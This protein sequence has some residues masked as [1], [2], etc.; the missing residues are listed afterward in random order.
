MYPRP[1]SQH[2]HA[3]SST[4]THTGRPHVES[5]RRGRHQK[6]T[7]TTSTRP[8]PSSNKR[9]WTT[10]P[11]PSFL[12]LPCRLLP[13]Q[14]QQQQQQQEQQE[15]PLLLHILLLRQCL[16][17]TH[18]RRRSSSSIPPSPLPAPLLVLSRGMALFQ[19]SRT[20]QPRLCYPTCLHG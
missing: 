5:R 14:Q 11:H 3:P 13:I 2:T 7:T 15:H 17:S 8:P 12:P 9:A 18:R 10:R 1:H 20:D 19:E 4:Y 6:K 16:P